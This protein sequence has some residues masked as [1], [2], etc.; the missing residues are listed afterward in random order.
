MNKQIKIAPSTHPCP[1]ERL[2]N[3]AMELLRD[4]ADFLHCD[5]MDG[6]FVADKTFDYIMLSMLHKKV[7]IPLDI[8]LMVVNPIE[9]FKV[10]AEAGADV[11]TFHYEAMNSK[12]EIIN[13]IN[14]IHALGCKAGISIK[15]NT[16]VD[17]II[18][19]LPYVDVVLVM[20]VEPGKSGQTYL[21]VANKKILQLS[22][23]RQKEGY[24][25]LIEV[26]GGVSAVNAESIIS[27]GADILVMGNAMYT[28]RDKKSLISTVKFLG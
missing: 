7:N 25:F 13:A 1:I 5:I 21:P 3:Y 6:V 12:I 2:E 20:S 4:G 15:P 9:K 18:R 8:H 22:N 26:D 10:Y 16:P 24:Q 27:L 14:Q 23:I 11:L 17:D 19:Y 28:S